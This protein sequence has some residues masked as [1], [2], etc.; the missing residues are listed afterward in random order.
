MH[1]TFMFSNM[2]QIPLSEKTL[3]DSIQA[4]LLNCENIFKSADI[5]V[6]KNIENILTTTNNIREET[7]TSTNSRTATH[8]SSV[9]AS[10]STAF[11]TS[12]RTTSEYV[13]INESRPSS[14]TEFY[15]SQSKITYKYISSSTLT[16]KLPSQYS[17][18]T[19]IFSS[20]IS[21]FETIST[22]LNE[23]STR[24]AFTVSKK[25]NIST[26]KRS[27]FQDVISTKTIESYRNNSTQSSLNLT[28][29]FS[30]TS[31]IYF[32]S[33]NIHKI[34][35]N[36]LSTGTTTT[37]TYLFFSIKT[38]LTSAKVFSMSLSSGTTH[39]FFSLS[40][41][42]TINIITI[43]N[44]MASLY[45]RS[46]N[47]T[48]LRTSIKTTTTATVFTPSSAKTILTLNTRIFSKL[49]TTELRII[50]YKISTT[51]SSPITI[52]T[53]TS[54]NTESITS[55]ISILAQTFSKLYHICYRTNTSYYSQKLNISVRCDN[56]YSSNKCHANSDCPN[57]FV[58]CQD[59][60]GCN[61]CTCKN[62]IFHII[63]Y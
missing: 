34:T 27:K 31:K 15:S 18:L 55:S 13:E 6:I 17:M 20:T 61:Q 2:P 60:Y 4:S 53:S 38:T 45:T 28:I 58:C 7:P 12:A 21:T 35:R 40:T 33:T 47:A 50:T 48:K 36:I 52:Q 1:L 3:G 30:K 26:I 23:I 51:E 11:V 32:S 19:N 49:T 5:S 39:T 41:T 8:I 10:V 16:S 46:K 44:K 22:D 29:S 59:T 54:K 62:S 42:K 56:R 63:L 9:G 57:E 37:T 43:T 25:L 24:W 14:Q